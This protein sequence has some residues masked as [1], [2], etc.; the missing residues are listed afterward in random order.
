MSI[1]NK[2]IPLTNIVVNIENP[3][4]E[5]AGNQREAIEVMIAN[6]GDKLINLAKDI[7]SAGLNPGKLINVA[8]HPTEKGRYYVLEGNRRITVLKLLAAPN[9][10]DARHKVFANKLRPLAEKFKLNQ[11]TKVPCVVYNDP[12]DAN[13]WIKL[14]HT[15]ENKGVG[16]V[17]WDSQQIGRFEERVAG[18][19]PI[20]L[21]VL[22]F[23]KSEPTVSSELKGKLKD[24]PST[25]LDRLLTD[26]N[27]QQVIGIFIQDNRIQTHLKKEEIAKG[28][29]KIVSDLAS[30]K[31][32]VK[33]IYTKEDREKYIETFKPNDIPDKKKK[34]TSTWELISP[35]SKSK[36][37]AGGLKKK[38][39]PLST[40]RE[41]LIPK[42]CIISIKEPRLNKIYRELKSIKVDNFENASGVLF[43]VFIELSLDSFIDQHN[44]PGI[45][46]Q[47]KLS[48]KVIT[49][50]LFMEQQNFVQKNMHKGI[51]SAVNN[52]HNMLSMETFNAYVHNRHLSPIAKDLKTTWDNIQ[53]FVEKMW[54]NIK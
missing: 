25:N 22:D 46:D 41:T 38:S 13:R 45:T 26:K 5:L 11:I 51:R 7:I 23:L 20:A 12:A 18:K 34:T 36:N 31:I 27:V 48:Q 37:T 16:T 15:G 35:Q 28:L 29:I 17:G 39:N 49:A 54:E 3:R 47:T 21:Q 33:D 9:L 50:S 14:E 44:V 52:K 10:I 42:D 32:K 40:D 43:R 53:T 8:P 30:K 24:V 2:V 19:S 4:F 6:Q 1:V